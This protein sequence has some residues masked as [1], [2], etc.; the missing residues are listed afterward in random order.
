MIWRLSNFTQ[1]C[2]PE[3]GFS[4][5]FSKVKTI[6]AHVVTIVGP[7]GPATNIWLARQGQLMI[8]AVQGIIS[9]PPRVSQTLLAGAIV[10][11]IITSLAKIIITLVKSFKNPPPA[12][13][14]SPWSRVW[15]ALIMSLG[16]SFNYDRK[17]SFTMRGMFI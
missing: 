10:L 11:A 14:L 12:P 17:R 1:A 15:R 5:D 2:G 16:V 4:R 13:I 6:L 8:L 9:W 3:D 7:I